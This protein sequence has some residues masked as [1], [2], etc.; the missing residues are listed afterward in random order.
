MPELSTLWERVVDRE[1]GRVV[2]MIR[3][4]DLESDPEPE[5]RECPA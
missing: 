4:P 2:R 1:T 5:A 3:R